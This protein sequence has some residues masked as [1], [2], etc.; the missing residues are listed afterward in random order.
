M[1]RSAGP[2]RNAASGRL[3]ESK[4][5]GAPLDCDVPG[6]GPRAEPG[7][8]LGDRAGAP[9]PAPPLCPGGAFLPATRDPEE[10]RALEVLPEPAGS[11]FA[12]PGQ[13]RDPARW[14]LCVAGAKLK[15]SGVWV[16]S[17]ESYAGGWGEVEAREGRSVFGSEGPGAAW[18]RGGRSAS[19]GAQ[20]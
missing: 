19:R 11:A 17:S 4:A 6:R 10:P 2:V 15:V 5:P 1:E 14:M 16:R 13:P 12:A 18:Y 3:P 8:L 9:R 7:A 20:L